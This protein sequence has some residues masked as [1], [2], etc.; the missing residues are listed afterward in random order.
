[1][2]IFQNADRA[3]RQAAADQARV[4]SYRSEIQAKESSPR[5]G[6][7]F[8]ALVSADE[9]AH[10][11]RRK[12]AI[13]E[14]V[15]ARSAELLEKARAGAAERAAEAKHSAE[16]RNAEAD[17]K[18]VREL[19]ALIRKT[20]AARDQLASSVARTAAYNAARGDRPF[21]LDAEARVR[22][23]PSFTR[24]AVFEDREE[25]QGP[26]GNT[27]GLFRQNE[28]GDLVPADHCGPYKLVRFR[29]QVR[30]EEFVP[31]KMPSRYA[32]SL[33]LVDAE[34]RKL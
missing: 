33:V 16:E 6:V 24:A 9:E 1:M 20:A 22:Q 23:T 21:I 28:K 7:S 14:G 5:D 32:D 11:L 26:A 31:A 12:L 3:E 18:L 4:A 25:W 13:A 34:G 15:A 10:A 27:P 8:E 29:H 2:S 19:D 17:K 30:A